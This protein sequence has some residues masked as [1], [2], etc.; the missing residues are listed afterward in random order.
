MVYVHV[1]LTKLFYW[2]SHERVISKHQW[3]MYM[4][5]VFSLSPLLSL[6]LFPSLPSSLPPS[7]LEGIPGDG[8]D[9]LQP[10]LGGGVLPL[11]DLLHD[12]TEVHGGL[13][14]VIVVWYLWQ[15]SN[16]KQYN[17]H[18][19]VQ[20]MHMHTTVYTYTYMYMYTCTHY[21]IHYM[22]HEQIR[23]ARAS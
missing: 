5:N 14:D 21:Y 12:G 6:F 18:V 8:V 23:W 16:H 4:P 2:I 22:V 15:Q 20:Y 9:L 19:H 17:V 10:L 1:K 3:C 7:S 11:I 13:D